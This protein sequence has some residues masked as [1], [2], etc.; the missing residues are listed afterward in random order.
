MSQNDHFFIGKVNLTILKQKLL[1]T[2]NGQ[3]STLKKQLFTML[4]QETS[5]KINRNH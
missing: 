1:K 5:S 3:L 2:V 4:M